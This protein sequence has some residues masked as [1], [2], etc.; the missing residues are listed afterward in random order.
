MHF[1]LANGSFKLLKVRSKAD[2]NWRL[3]PT[4]V[5]ICR[6]SIPNVSLIWQRWYGSSTK[7]LESGLLLT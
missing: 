5:M 4:K 3:I 1:S 6:T 2:G 7:R